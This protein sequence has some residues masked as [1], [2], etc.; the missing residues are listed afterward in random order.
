MAEEQT[1]GE[2]PE[3]PNPPGDDK[4]GGMP[5][6]IA[7]ARLEAQLANVTSQLEGLR[8]QVSQA[9]QPRP[10]Q[11]APLDKKDLEKAFWND[12]LGMTSS[13][14]N[15][16]AAQA[17]G[18]VQNQNI[19][20]MREV[21]KDKVRALDP[22]TFD[23]YAGEIDAKVRL[24]HPA[25]QSNI[26]V[27]HSAFSMVKGEH[28]DEIIAAKAAKAPAQTTAKTGDGPA[29]PSTKAAPA[30]KTEPLTDEEKT[31]VKK[32][33]ISEEGFRRGASRYA[34]QSEEGPSSWDDVITFDSRNPRPKPAKRTAA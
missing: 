32:F 11:P 23:R 14:A 13:I 1:Q 12:P 20:T 26:Q 15:A 29:S 18:F 5:P 2:H 7:A 34:S 21:A 31:F 27:W 24:V 30:P 33:K 4:K 19:E 9:S 10:A 6:D 17:A 22:E 25:Q 8:G 16:A 28:V 3:L